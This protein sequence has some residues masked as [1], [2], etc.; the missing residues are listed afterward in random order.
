MGFR[1]L[2]LRFS[3]WVLILITCSGMLHADQ[4]LR[5][6]IEQTAARTLIVKTVTP[7]F[8][9][10]SLLRRF[11]V[12]TVARLFTHR[13]QGP[14]AVPGAALDRTWRLV[15]SPGANL[16]EIVRALRARTD[17]VIWAE[18]E[19]TGRVA[20]LATDD[21]DFPLQ[22]GLLNEGQEIGGVAGLPGA[23]IDM[24]AA[25]TFYA[26]RAWTEVA[27]VDA[28]VD[29]HP[30][31]GDRL[32]PGRSMVGDLF[33]T[34]D[35]CGHGTHL[36]GIIAATTGNGLGIAGLHDRTRILPVRVFDGCTGAASPT[37]EG[38]VWAVDAG[39][40]VILVPLSFGSDALVLEEAIAYARDADVVVVAPVGNDAASDLTYPAAYE[41]CLGVSATNNTDNAAGFSNF[42]PHVDVAGP[43]V[44]I[45]SLAVGSAFEFQSGTSSAAAF[46]AGLAG[47]LRSYA[48][49]LPESAVRDLI[50]LGAEDLGSPGPDPLFGSGRINALNALMM[51]PAPALRF[52]NETPFPDTVT[53]DGSSVVVTRVAGAGEALNPSSVR[54]FLRAGGT[55][56]AS[57]PLVASGPNLFSAT[58]PELPCGSEIEYFFVAESTA[59]TSV[60]DPIGAPAHVFTAQALRWDV[61]F[62]DDFEADRGWT[63][64]AAGGTQTSGQWVRVI[65]VGTTAQPAFDFSPGELAHCFLTGQHFGGNAGSG[66]VDGGPVTLLSPTIELPADADDFE[67]RYARWFFSSGGTEPDTF[68][69]HASLDGGATWPIELEVIAST[70]GWV[71]Q[72]WRL[73]DVTPVAGHQLRLRFVTSDLAND[74]LTE[75]AIDEVSIG[76]IY[77][78]SVPGDGDG[79]GIF[80]WADLAIL[81]GCWS[82][83]GTMSPKGLCVAFDANA[84]GDVDMA[85]VRD[86]FNT[87]GPP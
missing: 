44:H 14:A 46:C 79:D 35:Y 22:W 87:F 31:L 12:V 33:D 36:A 71:E 32:L 17:S 59:G 82:G 67:I 81:A 5:P 45:Y 69:V 50:R 27:I 9:D 24:P 55:P 85:D 75:A 38:I 41:T 74:S 40:D 68:A 73:S 28:G 43:G 83:P 19:V 34:R 61:V 13:P 23:D 37:A 86:L 58:W 26:G 39:A 20:R 63:A 66:D 4:T 11:Q 47:L 15:L 21:P 60:F 54:L 64:T 3:L 49:Q 10:P 62:H 53:P 76:A 16:S 57:I 52:E 78:R 2:W 25:W 65:P 51:A 48:P 84:D 70:D 72:H 77:C 56:F 80:D 42:G 30:E 29:A 1:I 7:R 8:P 6:S 18:R